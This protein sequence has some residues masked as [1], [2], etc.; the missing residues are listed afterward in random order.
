MI[1][2]LNKATICA[3]GS[4]LKKDDTLVYKEEV[5]SYIKEFFEKEGIKVEECNTNNFTTLFPFYEPENWFTEEEFKN[6]NFWVKKYIITSQN[7]ED[8][9]SKIKSKDEIYY[10]EAFDENT[11]NYLNSLQ[12][13]VVHTPI[14]ERFP[15]D[16]IFYHTNRV[17]SNKNE[18]TDNSTV[19]HYLGAN[20]DGTKIYRRF[21]LN[22][23]LKQKYEIDTIYRTLSVLTKTYK[24]YIISDGRCPPYLLQ[25]AVKDNAKIFYDRT[26]NWGALSDEIKEQENEL[27]KK[28][29][30][31][32][33]SSQYLYDTLPEEYK[34][35]AEI[36]LNGCDVK[37]EFTIEKFSK[38]TAVYIGKGTQKID[39]DLI[40]K[41]L[42]EN[43]DWEIRF[44]GIFSA[45]IPEKIKKYSNFNYFGTIDEDSLHIIL[46]KCHIGLIPFVD[47]DWTKGM[48]PLKAFHYMNAN[49][50][51][52]YT[53]CDELT[54][55]PKVIFNLNDFSLDK[56]LEKM[57][58]KSIFKEYLKDCNWEKKFDYIN[59]YIFGVN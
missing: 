17:S 27:I 34:E 49:L 21:K 9:I 31:I 48:L 1:Y 40:E 47:T 42:K 29:T 38:K 55:Y 30:H 26:D 46:N 18:I 32:F 41:L 10:S 16:V 51:I 13:K 44:Y 4:C 58:D 52:A 57:I 8:V 36:V 56:I 23:Y 5:P 24:T 37:E 15:Y 25:K 35:K 59:N 43:P 20:Q 14:T 7:F 11:V 45:F 2:L 50:P 28:A 39:F 3:L 53:N 22:D 33:C 12:N 54:K 6:M 19:L